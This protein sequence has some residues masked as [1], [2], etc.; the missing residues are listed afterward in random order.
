MSLE[1]RAHHSAR[2]SGHTQLGAREA[3]MLIVRAVENTR[4]YVAEA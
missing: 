2:L 4:E 3:I 1:P